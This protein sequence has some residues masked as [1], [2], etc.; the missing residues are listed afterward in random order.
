MANSSRTLTA[1]PSHAARALLGALLAAFLL[2]LAGLGAMSA[3]PAAAVP[4]SEVTI[5]DRADAVDDEAL[6]EALASIDFRRPVLLGV[7]VLDV[8]EL[9]I[10]ASESTAL[11]DAVLAHARQE[12]PEWI[13][14]TVWA[15]GRVI[16][17]L[18]PENRIL[19]TYAGGDVAL[20]EGGF[21]SVQD[22]MRDPA[23]DGDWERTIVAGAEEYAQLLDQPWWQTRAA[24]GASVA[25]L[26]VLG[27]TVLGVLVGRR[28]AHRRVAE[29][30]PRWEQVLAE[31]DLTEAA[32]RTLPVQSPYAASAQDSHSVY[33]ARIEQTQQHDERIPARL[34]WAWGLRG[35]QRRTSKEFARGVETLDALDDDIIAANDLLHRIGN[36]R[37]AWQRE[38]APLRDSLEAVEGALMR[39]EGDT[40]ERSSQEQ[41]AVDALREQCERTEQ[42]MNHLTRQLERDEI[43]PDSALEGLD[44]LTAEL[45]QRAMAVR[46]LGISRMAEDEYEAELLR[47]ADV[48][49]DEEDA[50]DRTLRAQRHRRL[51]DEGAHGPVGAPGT[52]AF[53]H[54]S[55]VLW[56]STWNTEA[57][58][59][60]E[61]YRNP[62]TGSGGS[63]SG[64]SS[65]SFSGAGSSSRF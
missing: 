62:S 46:E 22:Q 30:R 37:S 24:A 16:L 31:R 61:S 35:S 12:R 20:D 47:E 19:G 57:T 64:Y 59:E 36:W 54:I 48:Y 49:L 27:V 40:T 45:S 9:G 38:Q 21:E 51:V 10:T 39:A 5:D 6:R 2:V 34:P 8:T 18:D 65:S 56:L 43:T 17:A 60:L 41:A 1:P 14:G 50:Y 7:V 33:L 15:N 3:P 63:T 4:P 42:E 13:S 53:W 32:A 52:D 26:G 29:A 23:R 44:A 58:T 28:N 11:N 25:T 55:P